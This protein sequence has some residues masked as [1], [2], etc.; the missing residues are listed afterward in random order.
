M[1]RVFCT[2][3][4]SLAVAVLSGCISIP[5]PAPESNTLLTG[6]FVVNMNKSGRWEETRGAH[7]YNIR[8]SFQSKDTGKTVL[9]YSQ[10]DGWFFTGKLASGDYS[11]TKFYL[12][13]KNTGK[14]FMMTLNGP[15]PLHIEGNKVNNMGDIVIDVGE[16]FY[17]I[18]PGDFDIVKDEFSALFPDSK[19]LDYEWVNCYPFSRP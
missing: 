17:H 1:R 15:F 13:I 18:T 7:K 16:E 10:S 12:E 9:A 2:V 19:W 11:I 8:I 3:L 4:V 14:N 6:K 5:E